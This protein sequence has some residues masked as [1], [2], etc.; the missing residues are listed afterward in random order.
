MEDKLLVLRCKRGSRDALGRIYEK[1]KKDLLI[2]AIALLNDTSTAE[3]VVHDVF[4]TF[5]KT[6]EKFRLTGSLKGY[7]LTCVANRARNTNK[8]RHLQSVGLDP[9]EAGGSDSDEPARL[10]ICN[11]QLQQLGHA[12]SQLPY[13]QREAILLHLQG[14]KTFRAIAKSLRISVNTVKSRYRYGL[15]KLGSIFSEERRNE[16]GR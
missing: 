3:D 8:A 13:E 10:I 16:T 15:D 12:M 4:V 6:V 2:L 7:L 5:V 1:H 9:A 14:T 11:E